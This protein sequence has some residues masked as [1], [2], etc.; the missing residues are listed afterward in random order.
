LTAAQKRGFL[1]AMEK[2]RQNNKLPLGGLRVLDLA[3]FVAG[4][5]SAAILAEFGADVIKI[6]Q[7]G[8]GD[9]LRKFGTPSPSGDGYCWLS[10][11]RNKRSVTLDLRKPA[12]AGIFKRLIE[13]ADV[14]C[15]NFRPGTLEKWGLGPEVLKAV[16]PRLV[17]LRI[18]GYGQTGPYKDR[19]GFARIAHAFGGLTYLTGEPGGPPLTPGSTSLADY[20]SGLYGALGIMLSLRARDDS[21]R[22]QEIDVAL[23][24]S[25]FRVLD[26]MAPLYAANGF[27]RPRL[28][29]GT[30]NV[31][32]HG[33]FECGDGEWVAIACTSDK[34]WVRMA[35]VLGRP[36]FGTDERYDTAANRVANRNDVDGMVSAFT[37][38]MPRDK[39]MQA[40]VAGDVPIAPVYSIADIFADPQYRARQT[41][42]TVED[43]KAGEITVPNVLPRL[44]ETPGRITHLGPP[45]G[46]AIEEIYGG[47]LG[48][49]Q[50]ELAELK[51]DGVI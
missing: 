22:G 13:G 4:P 35:E 3:T 2:A 5:F 19:P 20:I 38:S 23:Y 7:P 36:E 48:F 30:A 14:L 1:G 18:S 21:G 17:L 29:L 11:Q 25:I 51:R 37:L 15:E 27:V 46:D 39:L 34:M 16:N 31:C 8:G 32:P 45:L 26:E 24:E 6:E 49:T 43:E 47:E 9:P 40:C 50:A 41:L 42:V 12:G 44:S 10:E 33:H 28:G